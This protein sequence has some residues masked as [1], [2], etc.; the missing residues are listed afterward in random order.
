MLFYPCVY[1]IIMDIFTEGHRLD[2]KAK[3]IIT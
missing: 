1:E 2:L 3:E